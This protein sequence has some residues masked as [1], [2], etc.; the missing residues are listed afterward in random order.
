MIE[1]EALTVDSTVAPWGCRACGK[2]LRPGA[3]YCPHCGSPMIAQAVGLCP[4]C[5]VL[6]LFRRWAG[7]AWFC[8][9]CG[10]RVEAPGSDGGA[11][12]I[13]EARYCYHCRR[14]TV[15]RRAGTTA[16][17]AA[18]GQERTAPPHLPRHA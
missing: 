13:L 7:L 5:A 17:C 12:A 3:A 1:G 14:H 16:F 6:T 9:N 11:A 8:T 15:V 10:A 18:C 2:G 4:A